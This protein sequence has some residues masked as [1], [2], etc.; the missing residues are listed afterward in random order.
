MSKG[1]PAPRVRPSVSQWNTS[2]DAPAEK[3]EV[4]VS[5]P[6]FVHL[7]TVDGQ[8]GGLARLLP[9]EEKHCTCYGESKAVRQM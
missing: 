5:A 1:V 9:K 3:L 4:R 7:R 6:F 8:R 2:C